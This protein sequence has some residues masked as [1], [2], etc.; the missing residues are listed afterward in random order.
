MKTK[1]M[2]FLAILA[3]W[4]SLQVLGAEPHNP[5]VFTH[6]VKRH[7][8]EGF[9]AGDGDRST[10]YFGF[11]PAGD[12]RLGVRVYSLDGKHYRF[13]EYP[14]TVAEHARI[15]D[16]IGW[17]MKIQLHDR[18]EMIWGEKVRAIDPNRILDEDDLGDAV[19]L[20]PVHG[21]AG[22]YLEIQDVALG[23]RDYMDL[24]VEIEISIRERPATNVLILFEIVEIITPHDEQ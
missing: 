2:T 20:M 6:I 16:E 3:T 9:S 15:L 11:I 19:R 4:M 13:Y 1:S 14:Q 17:E 8:T 23:E 22:S 18:R 7:F 5:A 21:H 12:Y 10:L 24:T